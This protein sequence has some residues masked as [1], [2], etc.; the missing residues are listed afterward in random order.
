MNFST[1]GST[2]GSVPGLS[3]DSANT[4]HKLQV[5]LS[6]QPSPSSFSQALSHLWPTGRKL[7]I[8]YVGKNERGLLRIYSGD[9]SVWDVLMTHSQPPRALSLEMSCEM[10]CSLMPGEGGQANSSG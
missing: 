5:S 6:Q 8:V 4:E 7:H 3:M 1:Q 2:G 10:L 9:G